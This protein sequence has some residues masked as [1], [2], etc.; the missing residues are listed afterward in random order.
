M[1]IN[2]LDKTILVTGATRGIG[3]TLAEELFQLGANLLLTGTDTTEISELNKISAINKEK[4]KYF[5]VDFTDT[6]SLEIFFEEINQIAKI[7]GLVNNAGINI[8][9]SIDSVKMTDWERMLAVNLTAPLF[10]TSSVSKKMKLHNYGRIVNI[11]SIF[12]NISKEKRVCYTSTK[13]GIHGISVSSSIDLA[14]HNILIN[15]ISPGFVMTDLTKKNLTT[16]EIEDLQTKI[17]IRRFAST[18]EIT[19]PIIFLL[20][21]YNTY[22]TGQNIIVDGGF[23][24]V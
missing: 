4:K 11:G 3:K 24:I 23:T 21:S 8:L 18:H 22:L 14:Q 6:K 13:Y 1:N 20:S 19:K 9:N 12:G 2:F 7:D 15:T 16:S 10:L 5:C 17:P